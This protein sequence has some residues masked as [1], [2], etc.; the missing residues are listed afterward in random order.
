MSQVYEIS[1]PCTR[2]RITRRKPQANISPSLIN[3]WAALRAGMYFLRG[4]GVMVG[5]AYVR[6]VDC[7]CCRATYY[8]RRMKRIRSIWGTA[9][10]RNGQPN[11]NGNHLSWHPAFVYRW[12]AGKWCCAHMLAQ[13]DTRADLKPWWWRKYCQLQTLRLS[14]HLK[15]L[16]PWQSPGNCA[17]LVAQ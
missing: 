9:W 14:F 7:R 6:P 12:S 11:S 3:E 1:H 8:A 17:V 16:K 4:E 13:Y 5:T 15:F 10:S 2:G